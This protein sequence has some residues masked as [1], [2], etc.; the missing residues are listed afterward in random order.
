ME[1][2]RLFLRHP[3]GKVLSSLRKDPGQAEGLIEEVMVGKL[4]SELH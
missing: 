4:I 2:R 3:S 1:G